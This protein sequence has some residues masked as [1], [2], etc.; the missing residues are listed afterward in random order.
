MLSVV[1]GCGSLCD[2]HIGWVGWG[3]HVKMPLMGY[4]HPT[5]H[6]G[7]GHQTSKGYRGL[8][9]K[10]TPDTPPLVLGR[11]YLWGDGAAP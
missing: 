5:T 6:R 4:R 1:E 7:R 10:R 9:V 8:I 11:S 2:Y 3:L